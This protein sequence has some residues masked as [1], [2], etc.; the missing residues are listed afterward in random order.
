MASVGSHV[1]SA[2]PASRTHR[3]CGVAGPWRLSP[4]ARPWP[5]RGR[6]ASRRPTE[7]T[8][9]PPPQ[10]GLCAHAQ[11][12]PTRVSE[13]ALTADAVLPPPRAGL[14][15]LCWLVSFSCFLFVDLLVVY[16]RA[17]KTAH[18][19]PGASRGAQRDQCGPFPHP[20]GLA[21]EGSAGGTARPPKA[22]WRPRVDVGGDRPGLQPWRQRFQPLSPQKCT[23]SL[24]ASA[25]SPV[26]DGTYLAARLGGERAPLC[27]PG[28]GACGGSAP[29][30]PPSS[31]GGSGAPPTGDRDAHLPLLA[32]RPP[33]CC[34]ATRPKVKALG[35]S[36]PP[37]VPRHPPGPWR[38]QLAGQSQAEEGPHTQLPHLRGRQVSA[39]QSAG[40]AL[41]GSVSGLFWA[42]WPRV[43]WPREL[44]PPCSRAPS[45]PAPA[46]PRGPCHPPPPEPAARAACGC[47]GTRGT[48]YTPAVAGSCLPR[49]AVV[50]FVF[51]EAAL[52][53]GEYD[54]RSPSRPRE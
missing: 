45:P 2:A 20:P 43:S 37:R 35:V 32:P 51:F 12:E 14:P 8:H 19:G 21:V 23:Q 27:S 53:W 5:R 54:D 11:P 7:A 33:P 28:H 16:S 6:Q 10:G 42:S 25:S 44:A 18:R 17:F 39:A 41:S 38:P 34:L 4:G 3:H 36:E 46:P 9:S 24:G 31:R 22:P 26:P 48:D 40:R 50:S 29:R 15:G 52:L 1:L 47:W 13:N 49:E 30:P